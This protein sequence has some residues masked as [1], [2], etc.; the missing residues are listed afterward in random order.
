MSILNQL[1]DAAATT[2]GMVTFLADTFMVYEAHV[3]SAQEPLNFEGERLEV[4]MRNLPHH[5]GQYDL[6]AKDMRAVVKWLEN[7][8]LKIEGRLLKNYHQSSRAFS[9]KELRGLL[10]GDR[11]ILELNQVIIEAET[12]Q[13]KLDAIVEA[14]RQLGWMV[15]H[16]VKLRVAELQDV[17]I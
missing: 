14:F 3:Q 16:V 11:E 4:V 9:D 5:Q 8:R 15:G 10:N 2:E 6:W 7:H 13:Q 17:V 1:A 12:L